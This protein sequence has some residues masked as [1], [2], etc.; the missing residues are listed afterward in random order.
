MKQSK[1]EKEISGAMP[2]SRSRARRNNGLF[3]A[4]HQ[5]FAD[6]RGDTDILSVLWKTCLSQSRQELIQPTCFARRGCDFYFA[7]S[8]RDGVTSRLVRVVCRHFR[9]L[10]LRLR[11]D[12]GKAKILPNSSR[13]SCN[14]VRLL[15][16]RAFDRIAGLEPLPFR[17]THVTIAARG[18]L[19][20][21]AKRHSSRHGRA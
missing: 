5:T 6:R 16:E 13:S 3:R 18:A 1:R 11:G 12:D 10:G 21:L 9:I 8:F 4:K 7:T 14:P 2:A 20:L 17:V 19:C 15:Q